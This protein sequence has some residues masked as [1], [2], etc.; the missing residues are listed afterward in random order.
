M[1]A[2]EWNARFAELTY[3]RDWAHQDA[4][5]LAGLR[6]RSRRL[7]HVSGG[8][9]K[10]EFPNRVIVADIARAGSAE[11]ELQLLPEWEVVTL[12]TA[13]YVLEAI[14]S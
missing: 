9:Q 6:E 13:S 3:G 11:T 8:R 10:S 5:V 2:L 14:A 1:S 12:P 4:M 7:A